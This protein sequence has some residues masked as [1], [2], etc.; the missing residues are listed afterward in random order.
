MVE[1]NNAYTMLEFL[2]SH[3]INYSHLYFMLFWCM[4]VS[5]QGTCR[6]FVGDEPLW[7]VICWR[8]LESSKTIP[9]YSSLCAN[10]T[11]ICACK[12]RGG[13]RVREWKRGAGNKKENKRKH[14]KGLDLLQHMFCSISI[15]KKKWFFFFIYNWPCQEGFWPH[16]FIVVYLTEC[17]WQ[18][19]LLSFT[20]LSFACGDLLWLFK[21]R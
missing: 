10:V 18:S 9:S 3:L 1:R 4:A 13:G 11:Y 5:C 16:A 17:S 8:T 14:N 20:C 21:T 2:Q 19:L 15:E 7:S 12:S 6:Y